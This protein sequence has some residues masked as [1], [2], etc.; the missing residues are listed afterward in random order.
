[1]SK[2]TEPVLKFLK[3]WKNVEIQEEMI[4]YLWSELWEYYVRIDPWFVSDGVS[5]PMGCKYHPKTLRAWLV[6]DHIHKK[7]YILY[8]KKDSWTVDLIPCSR[9]KADCI[10]FEAMRI[11]KNW[12]IKSLT[13]FVW[14]RL[15]GWLFR[16]NLPAKFKKYFF[17]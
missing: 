16:H 11:S 5:I 7:K 10:F 9:F 1:M 13:Y 17:K 8:R 14:V 4:Y 3:D 12:I 15:I 2:F 6:H